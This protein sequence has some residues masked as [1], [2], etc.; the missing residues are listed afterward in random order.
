MRLRLKVWARG[1]SDLDV[2]SVLDLR[3]SVPENRLGQD[4]YPYF[5]YAKFYG[6][7]MEL[8]NTLALRQVSLYLL[9]SLGPHLSAFKTTTR[10]E[11]NLSMFTL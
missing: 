2:L 1:R 6:S 8:L 11:T 4:R 5:S 7:N 9:P 10:R 3:K